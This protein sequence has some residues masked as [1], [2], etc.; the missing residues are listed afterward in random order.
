[1]ITITGPAVDFH[2]SCDGTITLSVNG[3]G[4]LLITTGTKKWALSPEDL[5]EISELISLIKTE[6]TEEI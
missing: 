6:A 5:N 2:N 3:A 4:Q 1:V